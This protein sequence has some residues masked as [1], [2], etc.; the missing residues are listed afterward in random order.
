MIHKIE[1]NNWKK[2]KGPIALDKTRNINGYGYEL[3][4]N[5]YDCD[6]G[7]MSSA[8]ELKKFVIELTDN[9][10]HMKRYGEPLI[11]NF[12]HDNPVTSGFSLVQL[13]ETSSITGHFSDHQRSAYLNIFSCAPYDPEKTANFCKEFFL[14]QEM[15]AFF[16]LRP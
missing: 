7:K 8:E 2:S 13:I 16:V 11:P 1:G 9:V 12:G 6:L 15:D 10:I 3:V 14:A 5:L 4:I